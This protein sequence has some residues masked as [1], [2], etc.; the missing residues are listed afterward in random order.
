MSTHN[1]VWQLRGEATACLAHDHKEAEQRIEDGAKELRQ[2][3]GIEVDANDGEDEHY[4]EKQQQDVQHVGQRVEDCLH[5]QLQVFQ[6]AG[7]EREKMVM[8]QTPREGVLHST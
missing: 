2:V 6:G 8:R 3:R 5:Q 4:D 1:I 7:I